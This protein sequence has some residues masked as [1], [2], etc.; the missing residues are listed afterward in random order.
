MAGE[1]RVAKRPGTGNEGHRV[2]SAP[3]LYAFGVALVL[4]FVSWAAIAARPWQPKAAKTV[5]PRVL[6]LTAREK[7]LRGEALVL[8]RKLKRQW[9]LYQQSLELRK[10]QI[11]AARWQHEQAVA[12]AAAAAAAAARVGQSKAPTSPASARST[13]TPAPA[14]GGSP[15]PKPPPAPAPTSEPPPPQPIV[16]QLPPEVVVVELPPVTVSSTS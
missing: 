1:G 5:D 7:Q 2:S 6:A 14:P 3:R 4:F 15:T 10:S 12:A 8:Q 9:A 16:V 13:A 11:A